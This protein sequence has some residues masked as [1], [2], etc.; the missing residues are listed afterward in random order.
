MIECLIVDWLIVD[1]LMEEVAGGGVRSERSNSK[2][3]PNL[4]EV[5]KKTAMSGDKGTVSISSAYHQ[6]I[7]NISP[8]YHQYITNISPVGAI[9]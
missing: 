8:I 4:R 5:G 3:K 1:W 6:Y 9:L 2:R 7:T